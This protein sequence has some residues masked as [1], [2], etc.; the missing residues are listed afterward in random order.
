MNKKIILTILYLIPVLALAQ[1]RGDNL[2][3]QGIP[4]RNDV[5]VKAMAM[6]SAYTSLGGDIDA[7][8][9]N[10]AGLAEISNLQLSIEANNYSRSWRENQVYKPNRM[11]WTMSFYLEGLYTPDPKNNGV[12]DYELAQDSAYIVTPPELGLEPFSEE[13]ADW[14]ENVNDFGLSNIAAAYPINILGKQLVVSAAYYRNAYLDFDRNDTYLD[15]HIGYDA[16]G[17]IERVVTDTVRFTWSRFTRKRNGDVNNFVIGFAYNI[18][19]KLKVGIALNMVNGEADDF[20]SLDKVGYFDIAKDNRFRFSYDTLN[21]SINGNSKFEAMDFNVGAILN[22]NRI[23]LGFN[24]VTPYTLN[25]DWNY[26]IVTTD[27]SGSLTTKNS[28]TDKFEIPATLCL[29]ASITPVNPFT[30]SFGYQFTNYSQGTFKLS[31]ADSTHRDW[32]DQDELRLGI[33]YRPLDFLSLLAGYRYLREIFVPDGAAIRDRG[34][35]ATSYTLGASIKLLQ[36]SRLDFAYEIRRLKYHD[37]YFSNT[38]YVFEAFNNL[39]LGYTI[40]F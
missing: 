40:N 10:P 35:A 31:S 3:F 21:I 24:I 39:L 28:G 8:F 11:F 37:S 9:H 29:G 7:L 27:T 26:T 33:E 17:V 2:S 5:G 38:N 23:R 1:H 19:E 14:Q 20:Q 15:P 12:W 34:P 18:N 32:V 22:L 36:S 6:G 30:I 13:A 4:L 16:Y 25:R